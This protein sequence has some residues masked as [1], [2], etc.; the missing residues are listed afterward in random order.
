MT[1]K[2][3]KRPPEFDRLISRFYQL[4]DLDYP[5]FFDWINSRVRGFNREGE[6]AIARAFLDEILNGHYS[7]ED[8]QK[9]YRS[10]GPEYQMTPIRYFLEKLREA[11]N[12]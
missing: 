7:E 11:L 3:I 12:S 5:D 6:R 9:I 1:G 2:S 10:A 8:L 4:S